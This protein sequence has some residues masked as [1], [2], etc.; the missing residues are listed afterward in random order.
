MCDVFVCMYVCVCEGGTGMLLRSWWS[1]G[2]CVCVC[3][4]LCPCT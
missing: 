2:V 4:G 3:G 1:L